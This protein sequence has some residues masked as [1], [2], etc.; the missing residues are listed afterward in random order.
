MAMAARTCFMYVLLIAILVI[1]S[2]QLLL[3][4][5]GWEP[6]KS[7]L[8]HEQNQAQQLVTRDE[9]KQRIMGKTKDEVLAAAG[10]PSTTSQEESM[11]YWHYAERTKDPLT[12]ARDSAVQVV[13]EYGRVVA[14]NY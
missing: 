6:T 9:F 12:G 7:N 14:V 5:I 2:T 4:L 1:V 3:Y 8:E 10:R 13:F 11:S